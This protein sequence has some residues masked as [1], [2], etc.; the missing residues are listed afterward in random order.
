[1]GGSPP[2]S[3]RPVIVGSEARSI[4]VHVTVRDELDGGLYADDVMDELRF[5]V[6]AAVDAWYEDRG[7]PL[8]FLGCEPDV[9]GG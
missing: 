9:M 2:S 5:V 1:M 7:K 3:G 8:E 4:S 6:Q